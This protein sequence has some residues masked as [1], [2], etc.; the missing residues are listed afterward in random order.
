MAKIYQDE[1]GLFAKVGGWVA[2]P[3]GPSKFSVGDNVQGFHFGGST[4][5]GMGKI[6][7]RRGDYEEYWRTSGIWSKT[8]MVVR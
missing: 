4:C 7:G 8:M 5:I 1:L 2:R 6:K 3:E